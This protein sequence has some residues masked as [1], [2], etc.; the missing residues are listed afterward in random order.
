MSEKEVENV[1]NICTAS[2]M[3]LGLPETS[4]DI[5]DVTIAGL[6]IELIEGSI[7]GNSFDSAISL[8][9][10]FDKS[11]A[12]LSNSISTSIPKSNLFHNFETNSII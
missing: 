5:R 1:G 4:H 7:D 10:H 6:N 9:S 8:K 3:A 11:M 2:G 12:I